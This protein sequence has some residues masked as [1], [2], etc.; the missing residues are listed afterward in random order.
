MF[1]TKFYKN[2]R[3]LIKQKGAY[4]MIEFQSIDKKSKTF[5]L[6][7]KTDPNKRNDGWRGEGGESS[8]ASSAARRP[9]AMFRE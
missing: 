3:N 2:E 8:Y 4:S 7:K 5:K 6:N 1:L 9:C